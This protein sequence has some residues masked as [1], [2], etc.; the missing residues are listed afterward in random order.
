MKENIRKTNR[1]AKDS[2]FTDLFREVE[3]QKKLYYALFGVEEK[4]KDEDIKLITLESFLVRN[5]YNDLGL[6]VKDRLILLVEAQS[7]FNPNMAL[8]FLFYI[9]HTYQEYIRENALYL[10][11]T[12]RIKIPTPCFYLVYTGEREMR[13][14]DLRLSALYTE[15]G[16]CFL[17]LKVKLFTLE[18]TRESIIGEYIRFCK[19]YDKNKKG[20]KTEEELLLAVK[21]TINYCRENH[22]LKE[23]LSKK[24]KEVEDFM[25][26][27]FTEEELEEMRKKA[28]ER[29]RRELIEEAEKVG[30]ERGRV[31]GENRG[32]EET[33]SKMRKKGFDLQ[34]IMELT[35]LSKEKIMTL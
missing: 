34:T 26:Q 13:E 1:K 12:K 20:A 6:L 21:K 27:L 32:K 22:I 3:Y 8:R 2:V 33:A 15:E 18:N 24:S 31:L 29:E 30:E 14:E 19:E 7:T 5:L 23:Y 25:F 11:G 28:E 9:A 10:Y 35:G 4:L 16:K 17:E